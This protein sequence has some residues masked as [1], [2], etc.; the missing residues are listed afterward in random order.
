MKNAPGEKVGA[1]DVKG[2]FWLPNGQTITLPS[3]FIL[4]FKEYR[5]RDNRIRPLS[6]RE[7]MLASRRCM[8]N[9]EDQ[10][11]TS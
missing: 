8:E 4:P 9:I 6:I 2:G 3:A 5:V 1:Q 7:T 10:C 11:P